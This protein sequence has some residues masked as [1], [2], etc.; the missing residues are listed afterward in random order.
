MEIK[1]LLDKIQSKYIQ[2]YIFNYVNDNFIYN[3]FKFSKHYQKE[4][5]LDINKYIIKHL[6]LNLQI[7]DD[8]FSGSKNLEKSFLTKKL[9]NN[10]LSTN[11]TEDKIKEFIIKY[12]LENAKE[13]FK[14]KEQI[15]IDIYSPLFDLIST[16]GFLDEKF[17]IIIRGKLLNKD[18]M[19]YN[20]YNDYYNAFEKLNKQNIKYSSLCIDSYK[21][22][23][24]DFFEE[25]NLNLENIKNLTIF[26]LNKFDIPKNEIFAKNL[27]YLKLEYSS[28]LVICS[29][30]FEII[31]N[32]TSLEYL[33]LENLILSPYYDN[34]YGNQEIK[35][36][37]LKKLRL[38]NCKYITFAA[39]VNLNMLEIQSLNNVK[40]NKLIKLP[41][42]EELI[43][44]LKEEQNHII[45]LS[46][47]NDLKILC[48]GIDG[49]FDVKNEML[50]QLKIVPDYP[51]SVKK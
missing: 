46:S 26:G 43:Y 32:F 35:L 16:T 49:F 37:N 9:E 50:E 39:N 38:I 44:C 19:G 17:I 42:I 40:P 21:E 51:S 3:F 12:F 14:E 5:N 34:F 6:G 45:D 47:L 48:I 30:E 29:Q 1:D 27:L 36:F 28:K 23:D 22:Y 20:Y 2:K 31:N 33:I 10:I 4:L 7:F 18:N 24:A 15:K 13:I 11:I 41:Y 25:M 8:I